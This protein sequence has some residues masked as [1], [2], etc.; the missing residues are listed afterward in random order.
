MVWARKRNVPWL[1]ERWAEARDGR[2]RV[3]PARSLMTDMVPRAV[4]TM[5]APTRCCRAVDAM[6]ISASLGRS[7]RYAAKPLRLDRAGQGR[8]GQDR[9]G[10]DR[11]GQGRV[12]ATARREHEVSNLAVPWAGDGFTG[13]CA[14]LGD[15]ARLSR[16]KVVRQ[17]PR[18]PSLLYTRHVGSGVVAGEGRRGDGRQQQQQ[19]QQHQVWS[20]ADSDGR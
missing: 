19:Q 2:Y 11:K 12:H 3:A 16:A 1:V 6:P 10:R 8:T 20:R 4:G 7:V 9:T 17:T 13:S 18:A 5:L 14:K 15:H